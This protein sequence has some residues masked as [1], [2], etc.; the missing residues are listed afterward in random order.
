MAR[1][2]TWTD[3]AYRGN[4]A[5]IEV[6]GRGGDRLAQGIQ[7]LG[8]VAVDN[9][10]Q[11]IKAATDAAIASIANSDDPTAAAS[12]LPKDWT[13]DPL[14][15]AV[16]AN[17]R[18]EQLQQK[19]AREQTI[20]TARAAMDMSRAQLKDLED[21]RLSEAIVQRSWEASAKA[22]RPVLSEEDANLGQA[23]IK[24]GKELEARLD[25]LAD[26]RRGD[27]E[28]NLR[29]RE[30][31]LREEEARRIR[32]EQQALRAANA[33]L[34]LRGAS[35]EGAGLD[36]K[37]LDRVV[38]E[39][40]AK[41]GADPTQIALGRASFQTGLSGNQ[42]LDAEKDL[43]VPGGRGETFRTYEN[44]LTVAEL[45]AKQSQAVRADKFTQLN[46]TSANL[47]KSEFANLTEE[48]AAFKLAEKYG[49]DVDDA[50]ER[51]K[52]AQDRAPKGV[53]LTVPMRAEIA[54]AT[55]GSFWG[56]IKDTWA[57]SDSAEARLEEYVALQQGGGEKG[58]A[59]QSAELEQTFAAENAALTKQRQ[60]L[61]YAIRSGDFS[62]IPV[63]IR[64][65][66]ELQQRLEREAAEKANV[67]AQKA[68]AAADRE[69]QRLL[70]Q[71]PSGPVPDK[72]WRR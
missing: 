30:A 61:N 19:A 55:S 29:A 52:E 26:N 15:V 67:D 35:K 49:W 8:Q 40:Y 1:P 24:A 4:A 63:E 34:V 37:G 46:N 66:Y 25:T 48:A 21:T 39:T 51:M 70:G 47:A 72:A 44:A 10:N 9:R 62:A 43:P 27:A 12:A 23:S 58:V 65:A 54:A 16:A 45:A 59:Q 32:N 28:L 11:Q 68:A 64:R 69:L 22:G 7:G 53:T 56:G 5:A 3:V 13:I 71:G 6:F 20:A 60:Q 57:N 14:Q 50:R 42:P 2:I 17:A 31:K 36:P 18:G 41:F 38:L 33:E